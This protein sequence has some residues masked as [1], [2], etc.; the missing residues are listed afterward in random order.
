MT[1]RKVTVGSVVDGHQYDDT[2]FDYAFDSDGDQ[3]S[4]RLNITG[5]PAAGSTDAARMLD[6]LSSIRAVAVAD[7]DDPSSELA[8]L[9]GDNGSLL[10][11]YQAV[12][13]SPDLY[14]IYAF[15]A[16]PGSTD[17]P[18]VVAGSGG[19]WIA[20]AGAYSTLTPRR[21]PQIYGWAV[22]GSLV[23]ETI[24]CPVWR[25]R[26]DITALRWSIYAATAPSGSDATFDIQR[27]V[28]SG[29]A[30]STILSADIALPNGS[31]YADG[32][33][34]FSVSDLDEGDLLRLRCTAAGA[35]PGEDCTVLLSVETR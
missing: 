20:I 28:N 13:A 3:R 35:T 23:V 24:P 2:E 4:N 16:S 18:N 32:T 12:A 25:L 30:W 21:V 17:V 29:A 15:D 14:T 27:S 34:G 8:S 1:V 31:N 11:A 7:I 9:T 10:A 26:T 19:S 6:L 5:I 33:S 22:D